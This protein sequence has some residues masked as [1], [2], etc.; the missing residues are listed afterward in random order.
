M[1]TPDQMPSPEYVKPTKEYLKEKFDEYNELYFGGVLSPCK[2]TL[3]KDR[4]T[5]GN[6][7]TL[8]G[9]IPRISI[10]Q[11]VYWTEE[12]LKL[13]L[14]HEMVHHYVDT[15]I[16]P[17][18]F[19]FPHGHLF[20]KVCRMLKK[21]YGL[22]VQVLAMPDVYFYKEKIPTTCCGK[23]WRRYFGLKF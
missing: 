20:R 21:K 19:V 16:R 15:V 7:N 18:H 3:R 4:G 11:Y 9:N 13:T 8:R 12:T 1:K 23:L 14:I 17:K 5:F 2:M 10:A 22:K 6:Y